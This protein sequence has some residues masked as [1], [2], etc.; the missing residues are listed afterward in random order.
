MG[1]PSGGSVAPICLRRIVV[2]CLSLAVGLLGGCKKE[3][4]AVAPPP[5][6]QVGVAHPIAR[7]VVPYLQA[8]GNAVAYNAV[9]L[10]ARVQGF[11]AS[12]DYQDGTEATP[13]QSL[14]VIE[15]APYQ[16][17][18]QQA[19]ATLAAAQAQFTQ[20]DAESRRQ[21]ALGRN[22]FASQ[23]AVDQA[24][25]KRDT[26]Q[27]ELANQQA[28]LALATITLATRASPRPSPA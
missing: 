4:A 1:M 24:R 20:A 23:A 3:N 10:V 13:G 17:K 27:A 8:T 5:P 15:P 28:G 16:A 14:F 12:I 9:D 2:L 22:D 25:A 18:L 26:N 19:Q 6:P 7:T 11:V 21:S